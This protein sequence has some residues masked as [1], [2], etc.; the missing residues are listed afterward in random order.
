MA[1]GKNFGR[2]AIDERSQAFLLLL[3]QFSAP[4]QKEVKD[5]IGGSTARRRTAQRCHDGL[6][7]NASERVTQ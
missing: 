3:D 6:E 4:P 2:G 1:T 7:V 5:S